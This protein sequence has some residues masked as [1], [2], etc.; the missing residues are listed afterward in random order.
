MIFV[1]DNALLYVASYFQNVLTIVRLTFRGHVKEY[2]VIILAL[3]S[4]VHKNIHYGY[5]L[6]GPH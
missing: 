3:F 2:L 6:E 4:P 5:S 1:N